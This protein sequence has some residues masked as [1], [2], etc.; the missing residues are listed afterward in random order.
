MLM[1][2]M[3]VLLLQIYRESPDGIQTWLTLSNDST[4]QNELSSA[5]FGHETFT[6]KK[7]PLR[8]WPNIVTKDACR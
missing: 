1:R 2:D 7:V 6:L 8:P 3:Q 5:T 4:C